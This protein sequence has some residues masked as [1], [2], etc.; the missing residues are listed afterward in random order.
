MSF[1]CLF[2]SKTFIFQLRI[3]HNSLTSSY[4]NKL[5]NM[6]ISRDR[7]IP[8]LSLLS[9]SHESP[10]NEVAEKLYDVTSTSGDLL[11]CNKRY[12]F[13]IGLF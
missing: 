9:S 7:P 2:V 3:F 5:S 1:G 10:G 6:P 11:G 8:G 13:F 12:E 4:Q